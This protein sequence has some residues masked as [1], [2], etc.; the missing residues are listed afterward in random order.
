MVALG[1]KMSGLSC[2]SCCLH[3]MNKWQM[4]DGSWKFSSI[5]LFFFCMSEN[6]I[7]NFLKP[8]I[9]TINLYKTLNSRWH[10]RL[11]LCLGVDTVAVVRLVS[12]RW[13]PGWKG[14][15]LWLRP[16]GSVF[17][18]S[19]ES[20]S[21]VSIGRPHHCSFTACFHLFFNEETTGSAACY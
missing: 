19:L 13:L 5:F 18:L 3:D 1:E 8:K 15:A 17:G 14:E 7:M 10:V 4:M 20:R 21:D 2:W 12:H 11:M 6:S 9:Q 16:A